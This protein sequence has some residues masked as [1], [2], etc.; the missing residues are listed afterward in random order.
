MAPQQPQVTG[1]K[2]GAI[3]AF[4]ST[5]VIVAL[6]YLLYLLTQADLRSALEFRQKA[7]LEQATAT[8]ENYLG[9]AERDMRYLTR[10]LRLRQSISADM[11]GPWAGVESDWVA[12]M[13]SRT[14]L[15]DQVRFIDLEGRER[16]RVNNNLPDTS[17][18]P[19]S[20][21]QSKVNR[22]YVS[23]TLNLSAGT[24]YFSDFDLNVERGA[25]ELP[26]KP[27][28]RMVTPIEDLN[29]LKAGVVV[30]NYKGADM[31]SAISEIGKTSGQQLWMVNNEGHWL[32][33]PSSADEWSFMYPSRPA[34][35][36]SDRFPKLW[37]EASAQ[38][39][40]VEGGYQLSIRQLT[41]DLGLTAFENVVLKREGAWTLIAAADEALLQAHTWQIM[42][43]FAPALGLLELVLVGLS[44]WGGRQIKLRAQAIH[45]TA[46]RERQ[47]TVMFESAPDATL[48]SDQDGI[49]TRANSAVEKLLGYRP[50]ELI[51]HSIDLLVPDRIHN[52]HSSLRS[53]YYNSPVA[54]SVASRSRLT[55][56]RHDGT[57]IPVSI[58]LNSLVIDGEMQVLSAIR[59]MTA[60]HQANSEILNLN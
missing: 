56:R 31:L 44:L 53:Q 33:G 41:P 59:D 51:G 37:S 55:A 25:I 1:H 6:S 24:L 46:I 9:E 3:L 47:L 29:G 35:L 50:D 22:Y 48:M 54:R 42:R 57:E 19:Q 16:V 4:A 43:G 15:Y 32:I 12:W 40:V 60:D 18:V 49:I 13:Q 7:V 39:G 5:V 27:T 30:L 10:S 26:L 8:I 21:L 23:E 45:E 52:S 20:A 11:G 58:A 34:A 38:V 28:L 17:V 2:L 36:V 14:A